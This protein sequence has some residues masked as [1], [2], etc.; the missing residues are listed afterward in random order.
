MTINRRHFLA[1][2]GF[3]VAAGA[4]STSRSGSSLTFASEPQNGPPDW[5]TVRDQFAVSRDYI[6]LS[7]FFLASHPRPVREAI[8]RH[9]RA[10]DDNPFLYVEQ[11]MFKMPG[12]VRAAA[13]EY[14]GGKT[15]EVA[16]TN[17]TTMGL[18]FVY[19]GLPITAGQEIL[20]TM[21][22]HFVHHEA[23][24]LAAERAGASIKKISLYDDFNSISEAEIVQRIRKAVT[25]KTRAVGITWVHSGS[26]LKVPVRRIAEAIR[27]VNVGRSEADRILLI[28]DG[29]HG[30]GVEDEWVAQMGCDFFIAGTHKWIFGPRG[31]GLI[32]AKA[33]TWKMMRPIFP[34]FEFVPFTAWLRG[35]TPPRGMEASWVSPGGFHSFEYAWALP[36]A[37]AFH[38]RIGR[39]RVAERIHSLNDQCKEGLAR[40]RHVKLYTPLGNKLSAGLI[41]F[42]V[43]GM[44]S[45]ETVARLLA[46]RI[47]ASKAPYAVPFTR[48]APSLLNS[49]EEVETTLREIRALT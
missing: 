7:S 27:E 3:P 24:R 17:S 8:E 29:V 20:T 47:I 13:A 2:T 31:T 4:L 34:G 33:D 45:E 44:K 21:H 12:Q 1:A 10:I 28:V 48:L 46:R 23:I 6:H 41:C 30:F 9:Q 14:L 16:L 15:E 42:D 38:G 19:H 40:M 43:E 11:H 35:E 25:P 37:F 36:A 32:W 26:G 22:E 18:A 39:A 49:P 5:S